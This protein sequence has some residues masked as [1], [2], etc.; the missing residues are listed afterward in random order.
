MSKEVN[1][2]LDKRNALYPIKLE[3]LSEATWRLLLH[4]P[5]NVCQVWRSR[6][7]LVQVYYPEDGAIRLSLC[8][9]QLNAEGSRWEDNISWDDIQRL[10]NECGYSDKDAVEIY[11]R[12]RDIVNV[13]NMRHIWVLVESTHNLDFIWRDKTGGSSNQGAR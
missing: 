13:A 2:W 4:V 8:R 3:L 5:K 11:P 1:D 9:T 10:K 12:D 6:E 7:F